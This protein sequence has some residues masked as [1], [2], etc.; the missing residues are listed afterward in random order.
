MKKTPKH[1]AIFTIILL[2]FSCSDKWSDLNKYGKFSEKLVVEIPTNK[3]GKRVGGLDYNYL[4][5]K[6]YAHILRLDSLELGFT[7]LQIR[8]WLGH[9]MALKKHIVILKLVDTHWSGQLITLDRSGHNET[10]SIKKINP[11]NGW[12]NFAEKVNSL[13]IINLPNS[14][15]LLNYNGCGFDGI[16]YKFEI[17]TPNRYCFYY[18]CNPSENMSE[19]W[20]AK[21]VM[22]FAELLEDQF[23]F[24]YTK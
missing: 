17:A 7:T 16:D 6:P 13:G 19:F 21:N 1:S 18:Y 9:S 5:T 8:I 10:Y 22:T 15:E 3:T 14:E 2:F 24:E 12:K 4:S 23:N 20:Q 11:K